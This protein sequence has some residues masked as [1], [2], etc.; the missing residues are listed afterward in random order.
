MANIANTVLYWIP[1]IK[2]LFLFAVI[3]T[4]IVV[5]T[6]LFFFDSVQRRIRTESR[7]ISERNAYNKSGVAMV[8]AVNH[9][10]FPMYDISYDVANRQYSVD[11]A[12]PEGDVLNSF[13]NIRIYD[14]SARKEDTLK[15]KLCKCKS[16]LVEPGKPTYYNGDVGLVRFMREG[17][18]KFFDRQY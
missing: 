12:C 14:F 7:C 10:N 11:C 8:H 3:V 15:E 2:E 9:N 6:R 16:N 17:D 5:I 18:L 13:N 4:I 1:N